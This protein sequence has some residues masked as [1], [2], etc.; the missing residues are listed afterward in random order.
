MGRAR[1]NRFC[2]QQRAAAFAC[3]NSSAQSSLSSLSATILRAAYVKA[4]ATSQS[5]CSTVFPACPN[6][7]AQSPLSTLSA[8]ILRAAYV[9]A[10]ATAQSLCP[11]A[12]PVSTDA[13][14]Q[15]LAFLGLQAIHNI[16]HGEC[17][18][19][20]IADLIQVP[21]PVARALVHRWM[22]AHPMHRSNEHKH[23][24][25][26]GALTQEWH[27]DAAVQLWKEELHNG[28]LVVHSPA[29]VLVHYLPG[30][31]PWCTPLCNI[32]AAAAQASCCLL[33]TA[34]HFERLSVLAPPRRTP[35][36]RSHPPAPQTGQP[37]LCKMLGG[38][39]AAT[40][41]PRHSAGPH[42]PVAGAAAIV[43]VLSDPPL[44]IGTS[45]LR[46]HPHDH[47]AGVSLTP[48]RCTQSSNSRS[49]SYASDFSGR[50]YCDSPRDRAS[51][52][53]PARPPTTSSAARRPARPQSASTA[54]NPNPAA[55]V[56]ESMW[57]QVQV[58]RPASAT[59]TAFG[60]H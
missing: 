25:L 49:C 27:V 18:W 41:T 15:I 50:C 5:L 40:A 28:R 38:V 26:A 21:P 12:I 14:C 57:V 43:D 30:Y 13:V 45:P 58:H 59:A 3:A 35:P 52:L 29:R 10:A 7:S 32:D 51:A 44:A 46:L 60:C 48:D 55:S 1:F 37:Q 36:A 4:A 54:Y 31:P 17:F 22:Q 39:L 24:L 19:L 8:T 20:S 33:C 23:S 42:R 53:R 47:H 34:G 16:G 56:S 11:T 6:S 2:R 9:K